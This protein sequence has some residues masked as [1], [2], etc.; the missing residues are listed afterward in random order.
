M[1]ICMKCY[2]NKGNTNH[3]WCDNC[4]QHHGRNSY[5]QY[6]ERR[7]N[8]A[9]QDMGKSVMDIWTI[10]IVTLNSE[11]GEI[12]MEWITAINEKVAKL[13]Y[14]IEE[15]K[16]TQAQTDDIM[17]M[18]FLSHVNVPTD[19]DQD[20]IEATIEVLEREATS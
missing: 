8:K 14:E 13:K 10:T 9:G 20:M 4:L 6:L 5:I 1:N 17:K 11:T 16:A 2:E 7:M 3:L 15:R 12:G 19:T 18:V